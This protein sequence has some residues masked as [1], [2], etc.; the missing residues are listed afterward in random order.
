ML[1]KVML[2]KFTVNCDFSN[3]VIHILSIKSVG[4]ILSDLGTSTVVNVNNLLSYWGKNWKILIFFNEICLHSNNV[5]VKICYFDDMKSPQATRYDIKQI[6]RMLFAENKRKL[7]MYKYKTIQIIF[8]FN[9]SS[10]KLT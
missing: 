9:I 3:V 8:Y 10:S 1:K 2:T 7:H 6:F 5:K 4:K